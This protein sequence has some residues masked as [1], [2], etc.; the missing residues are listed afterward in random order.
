[1]HLF[2]LQNQKLHIEN[3]LLREKSSGLLTENEELRQRLGLDTLDSKEKVRLVFKVTTM[4]GDVWL[5]AAVADCCES[6][7]L[8]FRFCCPP[9][10]TQVWGSGLLSP[11]HSGYVCLRSRCRPSSL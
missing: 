9:G 4:Q 1:M 2:V 6:S 11:Q 10:T 5:W 7:C 3:R 8:R